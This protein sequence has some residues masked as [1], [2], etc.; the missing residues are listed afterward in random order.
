MDA[1]FLPAHHTPAL[2]MAGFDVHAGRSRDEMDKLVLGL[3]N[4]AQKI[5]K[6]QLKTFR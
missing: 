3:N 5:R 2:P 1:G 4:V 6:G